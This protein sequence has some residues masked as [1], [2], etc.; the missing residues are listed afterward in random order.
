[1]PQG[2][3]PPLDSR[4]FCQV[5]GKF[6][7]GITVATVLDADGAPHGMTANS[8][9][10][11]SL[12]PPLILFCVD[13]DCNLLGLFRNHSHFGINIL[14]EGQEALSNRFA[15]RGEDRFSAVEWEPGATG[16]PL[17]PGALGHLECA[18]VEAVSAGDHYIFIGEVVRCECREGEPL[19]YYG[20][21]Y[22]GLRSPG[23]A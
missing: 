23:Q 18:L 17:I 3:R 6:A 15:R 7:T 22:R 14:A 11:V 12:N 9:T 8:F 1:M 13:N 2:N 20:S 16:V 5:C 4:N 19:V 10:S 21:R